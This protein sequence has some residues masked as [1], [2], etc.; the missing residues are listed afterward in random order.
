MSISRASMALFVCLWK[1][2]GR[3]PARFG[4]SQRLIH[5]RVV[6]P[7]SST[8]C[9]RDRGGYGDVFYLDRSPYGNVSQQHPP[10]LLIGGTAQT[11]NSFT[12]H[13]QKVSATRRLIIPELRG[14]GR[15]SLDTSSISMGQYISDIKTFSSELGLD[16]V[17]VAGFS[18]GGRVALALAAHCPT[19]VNRLSITAIPLQRPPLGRM[20]LN[21]W[22]I[23]LAKGNMLDCAW[24]FILN[25]YSEEYI[26]LNYERLPAFVD[27]IV[28]NNQASKV[29]DLIR[30]SSTG[31]PG[32][33]YSIPICASM[34]CCPTQVIG[35]TQDR[36]AGVE[37]VRDLA[38]HIAGARYT[39]LNT[40]HLAPFEAP[41]QWRKALLEFLN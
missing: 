18:F 4:S 38:K 2:S 37:S 21:S 15:T 17:D 20:I 9:V 41:L 14:Q 3:R 10:L 5:V 23:S 1:H 7:E 28:A 12:P 6:P 30:L 25:G 11:V 35:A 31:E 39:E 40:G 19:L 33:Y 22:Q 8:I 24:S 27:M 34:V 16:C 36:I 26:G 13:I 32:D 29:Y